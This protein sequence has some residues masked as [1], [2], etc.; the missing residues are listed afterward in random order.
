MDTLKLV[1]ELERDEGLKLK[2]YRDNGPKKRLTIG[3]GRNLEDVGIT[4]GEAYVLLHNDIDRVTVDLN[5]HIPWWTEL[6]D[7]RARVI[8]NMTFNMGIEKLLEFKKTLALIQGSNFGK[9]AEEMLRS[10]W[11]VEVGVRAARLSR[12]IAFG[13]RLTE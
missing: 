11:A 2:P 5:T 3:I 12:M 6:E 8:A 9:A 1:N 13:D 4:R 7:T 10:E